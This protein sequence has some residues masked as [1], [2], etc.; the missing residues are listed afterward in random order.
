MVGLLAV[1]GLLEDGPIED[2]V[3]LEALADEEVAEQLPQVPASP[4]LL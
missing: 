2:V 1:G 4:R 3:V